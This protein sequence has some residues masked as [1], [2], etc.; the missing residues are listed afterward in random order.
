MIAT[1]SG[2]TRRSAV[3]RAGNLWEGLPWCCQMPLRR[4][5]GVWLVVFVKRLLQLGGNV[6]KI[7]GQVY[8]V[9][10]CVGIWALASAINNE[11]D[12]AHTRK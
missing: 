4:G 9:L 12:R 1:A 6:G 11:W 5:F 8:G 2:T 7:Q 10:K 3:L